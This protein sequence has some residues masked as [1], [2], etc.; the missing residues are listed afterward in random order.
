M[1]IHRYGPSATDHH[2]YAK[3]PD[4]ATLIIQ[5][6]SLASRIRIES[7]Y[8]AGQHKPTRSHIAT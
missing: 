1:F 3:H 4:A 2:S 5:I 6:N 8:Q 7:D